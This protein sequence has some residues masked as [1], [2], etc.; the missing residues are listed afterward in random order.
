M[1]LQL[2]QDAVIN[3]LEDPLNVT[4]YKL[5]LRPNALSHNLSSTSKIKIWH[6]HFLQTGF[7]KFIF[8]NDYKRNMPIGFFSSLDILVRLSRK[9]RDDREESCVLRVIFSMGIAFCKLLTIHF[10]ALD[11]KP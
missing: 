9:Q 7:I 4:I 2:Q 10:I 11:E 6:R 8:E 1:S 5:E 3:S